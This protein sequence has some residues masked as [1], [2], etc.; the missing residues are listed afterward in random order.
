MICKCLCHIEINIDA[1]QEQ[2][3][4]D[5]LRGKDGKMEDVGKPL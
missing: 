3:I 2:W 1:F 4:L 5:E